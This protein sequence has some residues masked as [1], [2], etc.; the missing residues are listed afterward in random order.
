[1][2][3]SLYAGGLDASFVTDVVKNAI[4][5]GIGGWAGTIL[6]SPTLLGTTRGLMWQPKQNLQSM[7]RENNIE[8][9]RFHSQQFNPSESTYNH[10]SNNHRRQGST[11]IVS[12]RKDPS[13]ATAGRHHRKESNLTAFD[14]DHPTST[15]LFF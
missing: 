9:E 15:M 10:F 14:F 6:C 3:K 1:M 13:K 8:D 11:S 12:H 4:L 2:A 5:L 7:R